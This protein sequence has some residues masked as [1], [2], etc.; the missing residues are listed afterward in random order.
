M[1]FLI[2]N[3]TTLSLYQSLN[4]NVELFNSSKSFVVGSGGRF[5]KIHISQQRATEQNIPVRSL[6]HRG[7]MT[8]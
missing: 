3:E 5:Q 4:L 2:S 7:R 1:Y 6:S 8:Q